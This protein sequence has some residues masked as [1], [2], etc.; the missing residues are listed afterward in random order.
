MGLH[1]ENEVYCVSQVV[2]TLTV[3]VITL[4]NVVM[5]CYDKILV[6]VAA[7][8]ICNC[9]CLSQLHVTTLCFVI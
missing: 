5:C 7:Y 3:I 2:N 1:L 6:N 9:K 4:Y 8:V